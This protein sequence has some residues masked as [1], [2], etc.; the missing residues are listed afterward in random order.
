MKRKDKIVTCFFLG[1]LAAGFAAPPEFAGS[2]AAARIGK[3]NF[4]AARVRSQ[5]ERPEQKPGVDAGKVILALQTREHRVTVLGGR[6]DLR[7]SV[8]TD[9]GIALA[10]AL[11]ATDLKSRFPELHDIVT[12]TAWAGLH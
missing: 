10:E 5:A 4:T 11:S 8:A 7:Y 1:F 6:Q 3:K 12:G 9:Q 2:K